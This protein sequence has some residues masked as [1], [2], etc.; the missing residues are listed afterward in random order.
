MSRRVKTPVERADAAEARLRLKR[1]KAQSLLIDRFMSG[2]GGYDS[3]RKGRFNA[4]SIGFPAALNRDLTPDEALIPDLEELRRLSRDAYRNNPIAK[5]VINKTVMGTIGSGLTARPQ[6]NRHVLK[7][8]VGLTDD[9][10]DS[11]QE[12]VREYWESWANET[13]CD[14]GRRLTFARMQEQI[15]RVESSCGEALVMFVRS[16]TERYGLRLRVMHPMQLANPSGEDAK[17]KNIIG[18]VEM[19]PTNSF[20]VAY[21][22]RNEMSETFP[23]AG[24]FTRVPAYDDALGRPNVLHAFNQLEPGQTRGVPRLSSDLGYFKNMDRVNEANVVNE[25]VRSYFTAFVTT[26]TPGQWADREM[27]NLIPAGEDGE[28]GP[29]RP[30]I[31][32]GAGAVQFL[33]PGEQVTIAEP[34]T[35]SNYEAWVTAHLKVIGMSQSIPFEV[36]LDSFNSSYSASRA[37]RLAWR[38]YCE[39]ERASMVSQV[40]T[41]CYREFIFTEQVMQRIDLPGYFD[42]PMIARAYEGV[43]W[44]GDAIGLLDPMQEAKA[45]QEM[46]AAGFSTKAEQTSLLTGKNW[47]RNAQQLAEEKRLWTQLDL[48]DNVQQ[49]AP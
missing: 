24:K 49:G 2:T 38:K 33:E 21:W 32:L 10:V 9:D 29:P 6:F 18:G 36:L 48:F 13:V 44:D 11:L 19:D 47:K 25:L 8:K 7:A 15:K 43:E 39:V 14:H 46:V 5:G 40:F 22:F 3:A 27:D 31:R 20:P 1:A 12:A 4:S 42:D 37:A 23:G 17:G 35:S 30:Q 34:K 28:G 41:P 16:T 45:G 26:P